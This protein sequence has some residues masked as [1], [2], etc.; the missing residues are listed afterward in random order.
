ML[1]S[2]LLDPTRSAH[3]L[4]DI[5]LEHLGYKA[6]SEEDVCGQGREG[7]AVRVDCRVDATLTYAGERADLALQLADALEPALGTRTAG[8]ASTATSRCRSCR[9]S[10]PSSGPASASTSPR[11][12]T[13][14]QR[15]ERELADAERADLR[16]RRARSS[17]STRR[18]SSA[19][20]CSTSC[21]CRRSSAPARPA[22]VSTAV[23]VLEELALTHELPR[24][25][26][27]W[28]GAPEAE[29][30]LHRRAA[31]ARQPG[32]RPRAHA[33]N[34]AVAATGRLSSSDPNLQ[35]I[36]I[37]TELGREIRRA[38]VADP[39]Q[40]A[41]LGRLLAD[42]AARARAP[43]RRRDAHRGVPARRGHPRP[44]GAEGVRRR[45]RARPA[46]AA[47]ARED[48]QLRAALR[49]NGVHAGQG[50][51]RARSR[52][53]RSSSTRTSPASRACAASSTDARQ[54]RARPAS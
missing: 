46:R 25:I 45:Q 30:H 51:R 20:S 28:R 6:L 37:R 24:L 21:S 23:E 4:E 27:E 17:T 52:P 49:K 26:L 11:S 33:F 3:A 14:S 54:T 50:H 43:V 36:P 38:F 35:N 8:P 41:D 18:S 39:G 7:R 15:I 19:T 42:R 48:H 29:G 31:A 1:A 44:H 34:Q 13:Q 16:A 9:C 12:P 40:R 22:R 2:Y 53:R 10:P 5:A 47:A 32:H